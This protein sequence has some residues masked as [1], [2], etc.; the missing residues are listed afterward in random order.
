MGWYYD[1][2]HRNLRSGMDADAQEAVSKASRI[3]RAH[4]RASSTGVEKPEAGHCM[5]PGRWRWFDLQLLF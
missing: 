2:S 4:D 5:F 3:W 1:G